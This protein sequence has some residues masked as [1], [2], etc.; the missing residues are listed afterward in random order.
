M[1]CWLW[2]CVCVRLIYQTCVQLLY[3]PRIEIDNDDD[4]EKDHHHHHHL[5]RTHALNTTTCV[6]QLSNNHMLKICLTLEKKS[7][8]LKEKKIYFLDVCE[9]V[10]VW[11]VYDGT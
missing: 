6:R 2:V 5:P 11:V 9:S 10:C 3:V 7:I 1:R 4:D 8:S